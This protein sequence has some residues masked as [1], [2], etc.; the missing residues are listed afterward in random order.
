M[1]GGLIQSKSTFLIT[2]YVPKR[3]GESLK[4]E[5]DRNFTLS[6]EVTDVEEEDIPPILL[7]AKAAIWEMISSFF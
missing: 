3:D 4:Q 1:L 2:G 6:V 5:L 7:K